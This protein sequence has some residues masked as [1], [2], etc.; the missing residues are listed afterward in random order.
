MK[1]IKGTE[2]KWIFL[3]LIILSVIFVAH[4]AANV[5]LYST[6]MDE[7]NVLSDGWKKETDNDALTVKYSRIISDEVAGN[8]IN[9]YA[10]DSFVTA[11]LDGEEV[12]HYGE[13]TKFCKSPASAQHFIR[14][15]EDA[16]GKELVIVIRSVYGGSKFITDYKISYGAYGEIVNHILH[17]EMADIILNALMFGLSLILFILFF[18][19]Y[20]HGIVEKRALY[21]GLIGLL[22]VLCSNCDL[23]LFQMMLPY[24][25]PQYY[26]YYFLMM[27]LPIMFICYLEAL[28][29]N[30]SLTVSYYTH[31]G[32]ILVFTVLHFTGLVEYAESL[33]P[34]CA[35]SAIEILVAIVIAVRKG[36]THRKR[37][38]AGLCILIASVIINGIVFMLSPNGYSSLTIIKIGVCLYMCIGIFEYI[39]T[40]VYEM[41]N[42]KNAEVLKKKAYTD[43]LTGLGNRYAFAE[44]VADAD[45]RRLS[46]VS[47]D[48]NNLKF[49]NDRFGHMYG[50]RLILAAAKILS[51]VFGDVFRTGGDEFI[52]VLTDVSEAKLEEMKNKM[53]AMAQKQSSEDMIIE[54]ACGYSSYV[55]T[56]LTYEEIMR[57]ADGLMYIHKQEL[58]ADSGVESVR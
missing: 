49:Y 17:G 48:L 12:Y 50:D 2:R 39:S 16:A 25:I 58:K 18:S 22:L 3:G 57:R 15:S 32:V 26:V 30:G 13:A 35:I 37:L 44:A 14:L 23:Y 21:L 11:Y 41:I 8:T 20:K 42:V 33:I 34:Y 54:I 29:A 9:F 19:E 56:D 24:G 7:P 31:L 43:H 52:A 53:C 36:I 28:A 55:E 45:L 38:R 10:Y 47:F 40:L 46:I 27:M 4:L 1:Y 51:N 5:T 6:S